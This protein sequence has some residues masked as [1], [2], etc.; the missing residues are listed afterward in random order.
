MPKRTKY[1]YIHTYITKDLY[2]YIYINS[3][4][5]TAVNYSTFRGL[6]ALRTYIPQKYIT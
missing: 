6:F 3:T 4:R 1:K 2:T 5:T